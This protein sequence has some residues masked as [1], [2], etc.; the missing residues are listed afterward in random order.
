MVDAASRQ[1]DVVTLSHH[2]LSVEEAVAAVTAP[3]CGAVSLF[4]GVN[5]DS[6]EAR[7]VV[8][9]EY[10]AY[11]S[12][13][14]T[15]MRK[16]CAAMRHQWPAVE[17]IAVAHRLGFC[18]AVEEASVVIAVSSPNRRDSLDAVS[19]CIDSLKATVL[20]LDVQ[21]VYDTD[22]YSW[23]ENKE[24]TWAEKQEKHECGTNVRDS[25]DAVDTSS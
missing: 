16:V 24:C 18:G 25:E 11:E 5:R 10:E 14:I 23:R 3:C 8:R 2:K 7:R 4:I 9:L 1:R 17:Y 12:M 15:E 21:E 6:F 20:C 13:A 19:Y 22:E